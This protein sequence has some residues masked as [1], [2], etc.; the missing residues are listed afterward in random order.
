MTNCSSA[1]DLGHEIK[2]H[3]LSQ[4]HTSMFYEPSISAGQ[5]K[6]FS[7]DHNRELTVRFSSQIQQFKKK[8][9][10]KKLAMIVLF[11]KFFLIFRV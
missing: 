3:I 5:I 10:K 9:K 1:G 7:V 11:L 6:T 8:K 2:S 4:D